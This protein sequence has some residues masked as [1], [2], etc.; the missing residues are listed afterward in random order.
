M[1]CTIT[2][3][4]IIISIVI[5][6]ISL[7]LSLYRSLLSL[8]RYSIVIIVIIV[9]IEIVIIVIDILSLSRWGGGRPKKE[10]CAGGVRYGQFSKFHVCFCGL[11]PCTV[12]SRS[13]PYG[14]VS[15]FQT[16]GMVT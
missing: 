11:G 8:S 9:I 4:I 10:R 6:I 12:R 2:I 5:I 3:V 1:C 14:H 15:C 7:L 16:S 13:V